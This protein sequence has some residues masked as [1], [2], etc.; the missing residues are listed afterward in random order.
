MGALPPLIYKEIKYC[1]DYYHLNK[2][3]VEFERENV[4]C[5]G[6]HRDTEVNVQSN[7]ISDVT[8]QKGLKLIKLEEDE[9]FQKAKLAVQVVNETYDYY[10]K[11]EPAKAQ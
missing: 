7:Q 5:A 2:D 6:T 11:T 4:I 1:F 9:S 8:A 10:I 3:K